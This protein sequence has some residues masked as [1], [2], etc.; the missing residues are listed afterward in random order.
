M[1]P[2]SK[3]LPQ[4]AKISAKVSP[5]LSRDRKNCWNLSFR[6]Q[7]R[8]LTQ[9]RRLESNILKPGIL[10]TT[11]GQMEPSPSQRNPRGP[12]PR[13]QTSIAKKMNPRRKITMK[14]RNNFNRH[15]SRFPIKMSKTTESRPRYPPLSQYTSITTTPATN[16]VG[17]HDCL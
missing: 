16:G 15:L 1:S 5:S 2:R 6:T 11:S 10:L 8:S 14:P 9:P 12:P 3:K 17:F 13:N 7:N 4:G